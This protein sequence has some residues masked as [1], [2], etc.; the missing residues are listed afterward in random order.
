MTA[1]KYLV[2]DVF[3]ANVMEGNPLAVCARLRWSRRRGDAEN[4]AREFNLSELVF[5]LPPKNPLHRARVRIF[6][7]S[8]EMPFAGH[9]TVGAAVALAEWTAARPES[10]CW[11]KT[12]ARCAAP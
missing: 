4:R 8:R 11:K 10:S 3:T 1:R 6:T 9:P 2:Y 7:P 12:S 5:I